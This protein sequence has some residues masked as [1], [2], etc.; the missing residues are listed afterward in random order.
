M[1]RMSREKKERKPSWFFS[2]SFASSVMDG[3]VQ[4]MPSGATHHDAIY[5]H[6]S[7]CAAGVDIF[8]HA[9]L[10]FPIATGQHWSLV[11]ASMHTLRG[12]PGSGS[13]E[14]LDSSP[15]RIPPLQAMCRIMSYCVVHD[16]FCF[17]RD[18]SFWKS[19]KFGSK[20]RHDD[21]TAPSTVQSGARA[22]L[23]SR[24]S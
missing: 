9:K 7:L 16:F 23:L 6:H 24:S 11:V 4:S 10:F 1:S 2:S 15:D 17:C 13:L 22:S 19:A 20:E 21:Y 14:Y 3:E 8:G 18:N 12:G 5:V